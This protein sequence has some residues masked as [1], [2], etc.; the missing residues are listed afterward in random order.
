MSAH[1]ILA[2][3]RGESAEDYRSFVNAKGTFSSAPQDTD[4]CAWAQMT[5]VT[6]TPWQSPAKAISAHSWMVAWCFWRRTATPE[7]F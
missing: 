6:L 7:N 4:T 1:T 5:M 2:N 3:W